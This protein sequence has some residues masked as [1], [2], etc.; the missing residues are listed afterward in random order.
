MF[1]NINYVQIA[2]RYIKE[3]VTD[4][5]NNPYNYFS[6][7]DVKC[8]LFMMMY[9]NSAISAPKQ[10]IDGKMISPLH[11]EVT[12]CNDKGKLLFHVDLSIVD[13]GN[14]DVY[15]NPTS[16]GMRFSKGYRAGECYVAIEIKLNKIGDKQKMLERW[17]KDMKKLKDIKSRNPF[18]TCYS[19]L[20][21]KKNHIQ[22]TTEP[23]SFRRNYPQTRIIYANASG[24]IFF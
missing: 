16:E 6:E 12:Y 8:R 21:D 7:S 23:S 13:P 10:T 4:F 15:S 19:I 24:V 1:K 9:K 5:K 14:T 20:L 22:E 3:L 17:K 2:E 11:S 18:L